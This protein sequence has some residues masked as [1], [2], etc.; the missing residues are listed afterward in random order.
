MSAFAESDS[1]LKH[2]M[3]R[4]GV[5]LIELEDLKDPHGAR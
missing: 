5:E 1:G 3:H 2:L 4:A